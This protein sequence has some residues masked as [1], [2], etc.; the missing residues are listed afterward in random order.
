MAGEVMDGLSTFDV[1]TVILLLDV[2]VEELTWL[3]LHPIEAGVVESLRPSKLPDPPTGRM[4]PVGG[5]GV[6]RR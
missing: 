4:R 5:S 2:P 3:A 1:V 6:E